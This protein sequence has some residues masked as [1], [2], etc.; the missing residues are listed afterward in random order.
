MLPLFYSLTQGLWNLGFNLIMRVLE[1]TPPS[2]KWQC[3]WGE[4]W[5]KFGASSFFWPHHLD[6]ACQRGW[7]VGISGC[8]W[9]ALAHKGP[10]STEPGHSHCCW[11]SLNT[12]GIPLHLCPP[13]LVVRRAWRFIHSQRHGNPKSSLSF[14]QS[15]AGTKETAI[16]CLQCFSLAADPENQLQS[17]P[18]IVQSQLTFSM[19]MSMSGP[20]GA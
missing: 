14:S 4:S 17:Q 13:G 8:C 2:E 1:T 18:Y 16:F 6:P 10:S 19:T 7:A 11:H 5:R 15:R 20:C 3:L 9:A 12:R